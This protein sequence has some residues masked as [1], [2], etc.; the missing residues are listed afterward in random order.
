VDQADSAPPSDQ[1][2]ALEDAD[3]D[4]LEAQLGPLLD[5]LDWVPSRS[6]NWFPS[7]ILFNEFGDVRDRLL[8][9]PRLGALLHVFILHNPNDGKEMPFYPHAIS[10][11]GGAVLLHACS[12]DN[13]GWRFLCPVEHDDEKHRHVPYEL[14]YRAGELNDVLS[15]IKLH[16]HV[17]CL[18][19]A[20]L[21]FLRADGLLPDIMRIVARP[22]VVVP[23]GSTRRHWKWFLKDVLGSGSRY[24]W[25]EG[26]DDGPLS[27]RNYCFITRSDGSMIAMR[28]TSRI[29]YNQLVKE[30]GDA[31]V[32]ATASE[33]ANRF[34]SEWLE[35]LNACAD[36]YFRYSW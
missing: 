18:W 15:A 33:F 31:T 13:R 17:L 32:I 16:D 29:V 23:Q 10:P 7:G 34:S 30:G 3:N 14:L 27:G 21:R 11:G 1:S 36:H 4:P 25:H 35:R 6:T 24:A 5:T 9:T 26:N 19:E 28:P 12:P 2:R 20:G 8:S 22:I